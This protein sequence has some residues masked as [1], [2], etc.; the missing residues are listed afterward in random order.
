MKHLKYFK[1]QFAEIRSSSEIDEFKGHKI[2]PS[3]ENREEQVRFAD[4]L[5]KI[6]NGLGLSVS[7]VVKDAANCY[8]KWIEVIIS[9]NLTENPF[10]LLSL[11]LGYLN[12][13][14]KWTE[15]DYAFFKLKTNKSIYGKIK[16]GAEKIYSFKLVFSKAR[17]INQLKI[18]DPNT[19]YLFN[20]STPEEAL[21]LTIREFLKLVNSCGD[22]IY[23]GSSATTKLFGIDGKKTVKGIRHFINSYLKGRLTGYDR[24]N[25][26]NHVNRLSGDSNFYKAMEYQKEVNPNIF[27][28]LN[29]PDSHM[30]Q[31]K[32]LNDIGFMDD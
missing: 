8:F 1:E 11:M 31:G 20:P 9:M 14:N 30:N 10:G 12:T 29:I 7:V 32:D 19:W 15:R 23:S 4:M 13:S 27:N 2:A 6:F 22:T 28:I 18:D 25:I 17:G 21:K 5:E 16:D 26:I 24:K 3:I